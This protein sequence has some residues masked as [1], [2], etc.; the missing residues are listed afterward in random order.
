MKN[1]LATTTMAAVLIWSGVCL[2][3]SIP[4]TYSL[5]KIE[6]VESRADVIFQ[7]KALDQG[8]SSMLLKIDGKR[9]LSYADHMRPDHGA[10]TLW[11]RFSQGAPEVV[12]QVRLP[13]KK[14]W[15]AGREHWWLSGKET[16]GN[17]TQATP[18]PEPA[19]M[20][21]FGTGIA[22]LSATIR[23]RSREDEYSS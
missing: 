3:T 13:G 17:G 20:L 8:S 5:N 2:A 4:A 10:A 19:T 1:L 9:L 18:T 15:L 7:H 11:T 22:A 6:P 23:R 14:W 16:N 21:L 12:G